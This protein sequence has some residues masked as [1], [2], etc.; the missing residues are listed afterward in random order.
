MRS[1]DLEWILTLAGALRK[2]SYTF[3]P[4]APWISPNSLPNN[5]VTPRGVI[6]AALHKCPSL[7]SLAIVD[8]GLGKESF[9]VKCHDPLESDCLKYFSFLEDLTMPM[10]LLP[11]K[12]DGSISSLED[13]EFP[14]SL[15]RL[16]LCVSG[17]LSWPRWGPPPVD[18]ANAVK[19]LLQN[20][21]KVAP[22]LVRLHIVFDSHRNPFTIKHHTKNVTAWI[23]PLCV[24]GRKSHVE[25]AASWRTTALLKQEWAK[26]KETTQIV[27]R[28]C[29]RTLKEEKEEQ[30]E[31]ENNWHSQ[32]LPPW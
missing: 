10:S 13:F 18:W 27:P 30:K 3:G 2:L 26:K 15:L 8:A 5:G 7:T 20:K 22:S 29:G 19:S 21:A 16:G 31:R 11:K 28:P 4:R 6:R 17:N 32:W 9:T 25:V 12:G 23:R 1:K 14:P 24:L